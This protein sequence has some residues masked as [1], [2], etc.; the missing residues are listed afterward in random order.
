MSALCKGRMVM[1][2]HDKSLCLRVRPQASQQLSIAR[3]AIFHVTYHPVSHLL[4]I[5]RLS[6]SLFGQV[7]A[8]LCEAMTCWAHLE[9]P[10]V[11]NPVPDALG[12]QDACARVSNEYGQLPSASRAIGMAGLVMSPIEACEGKTLFL[13]CALPLAGG[14][15]VVHLLLAGTLLLLQ[16]Q[17]VHEGVSPSKVESGLAYLAGTDWERA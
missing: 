1:F 2:L 12:W 7:I 10:P 17:A 14:G 15:L 6:C 5:H 11:I 3:V 8:T 9:M 13:K 16:I 4:I